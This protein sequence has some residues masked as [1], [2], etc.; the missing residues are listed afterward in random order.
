MSPTLNGSSAIRRFEGSNA[1]EIHDGITFDFYTGLPH[2]YENSTVQLTSVGLAQARPNKVILSHVY[3]KWAQIPSNPLIQGWDIT[4][5]LLT[6]LVL[7]IAAREPDIPGMF[8]CH[9][10]QL[11]GQ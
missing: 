2:I 5:L 8:I 3:I 10:W 1:I 7:S 9:F 6:V 4:F 11:G